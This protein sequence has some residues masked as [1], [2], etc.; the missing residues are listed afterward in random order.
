MRR[1]VCQCIVYAVSREACQQTVPEMTY[2]LLLCIERK[3]KA[4]LTHLG[5]RTFVQCP[6]LCLLGR[7]MQNSYTGAFWGKI[8]IKMSKDPTTFQT[9]RYRPRPMFIR[10]LQGRSGKNTPDDNIQFI[11]NQL[12]DFKIA[13]S[14]SI[15]ALGLLTASG[16]AEALELSQLVRVEPCSR[17]KI[18]DSLN[19]FDWKRCE[20]IWWALHLVQKA[21]KT[22]AEFGPP[23]AV[24]LPPC[25]RWS[26]DKAFNQSRDIVSREAIRGCAGHVVSES[27]FY[28]FFYNV[29]L[30][31]C[32][33]L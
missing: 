18:S 12:P 6:W 26:S 11:R 23:R 7:P 22:T 28:E 8:A 25:Q 10:Y 15:L 20:S 24:W 30:A 21:Y 27:G 32:S 9:S 14:C 3:I 31:N 5:Q 29:Q 2:R 13:W 19:F 33:Q 4:L 17:Q 16:S 1:E